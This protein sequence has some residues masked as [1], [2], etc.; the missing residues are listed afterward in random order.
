MVRST[1]QNHR[2][3]V[4]KMVRNRLF[5]TLTEFVLECHCKSRYDKFDTLN[6]GDKYT[7]KLCGPTSND[8]N[9]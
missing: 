2:F 9:W 5:H 7:S 8:N 6:F 3:Y 1:E 4:L